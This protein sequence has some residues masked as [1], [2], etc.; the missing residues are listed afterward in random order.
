MAERVNAMKLLFFSCLLILFPLSQSTLSRCQTVV[1]PI[2]VRQGN[3]QPIVH[4][5][6]KL[7]FQLY[8]D[9]LIV[10]RGSIGNLKNLN[11][12]ID[13]GACPS[14]VDQ[15]VAH[16][17]RLS[18]EPRRV[19]LSTTT[20]DAQLVTLPSILIGPIRAE[21]LPVLA[22]DLSF[23]GKNLGHKVDAIVGMDVLRNSSFTLDYKNKEMLLGPVQSFSSYIPFDTETPVVTVRLRLPDRQLR[24]VVDS[25][26]P[27]LMLF[28]SRVLNSAGFE[29]LG[30]ENV[31][32]LSG[33]FQRKKVR[34]PEVY[35]DKENVGPQIAFI[36][37]DRKDDGDDFDGVLG[38][39]G[40]HFSKI[41]F[42]FERRRF[43]W[44]RAPVPAITVSV[45]DDIRLPPRVL[46]DAEREATRIYERAGVP[47]LWIS[48]AMSSDAHTDLRCREQPSPMHLNVRIVPHAVT[49]SDSVFGVAFLSEEGTGVYTDVFYDSIEKL[50][51]DSHIGSARVLGHVMAHELGHLILGSNAH[52][53]WGVMCPSWHREELR[54][55]SMGNLVFSE[56]QARFMR[57][58]LSRKSGFWSRLGK[59]YCIGNET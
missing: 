26:T 48:C 4:A 33:T 42:D 20:V 50:D 35:L 9:Y 13:T 32:D 25:G 6:V 38:F 2:G 18:Q 1:A 39:R 10:V 44:E 34:I 15:K 24:L 17:L 8:W 40:P 12:L 49:A 30:T 36:A 21:S 23:F 22:E 51:Q 53:Y 47:I 31:A 59:K 46:A 11:F 52:S 5:P 27:D 56:E 58:R 3:I 28:Q 14:V 19:N 7:A 45:Y 16:N 41:A 29:S 55:A 57:E 43:G 37:D 54:L